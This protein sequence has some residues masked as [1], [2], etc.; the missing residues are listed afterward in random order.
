MIEPF[1]E[2]HSS[3][4]IEDLTIENQTDRI[5][6]YGNL[7]VSKDQKGLE[8][9]KKLYVLLGRI[10]AELESQP[11]LQEHVQ[12]QAESSVDNPFYK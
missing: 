1:A 4:M 5:N 3:F 10:V 11:D 2:D 12:Q 9:A 6:F 7:Q 8:T